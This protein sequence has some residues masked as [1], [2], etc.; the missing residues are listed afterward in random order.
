[1]QFMQYCSTKISI[2]LTFR[3][4]RAKKTLLA[5]CNLIKRNLFTRS[6]KHC[7]QLNEMSLPLRFPGIIKKMQLEGEHFQWL[8]T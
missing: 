6:I 3:H 5:E 2:S 1:M 7:K 4:S 8:H